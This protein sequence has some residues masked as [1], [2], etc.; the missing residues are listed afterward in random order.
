M[1][2]V[3]LLIL[4]FIGF[5]TYRAYRNG[6]IREL[7][8][9]CGVVLAVPLAGIFYDDMFPKV[10]PIVDNPELASLISFIAILAGVIIGAQVLAYFLRSAVTMLNL[11]VLDEIAGGLFGFLKGIL[12]VQ[13]LLIA[14]WVFPSPDLRKSIEASP[15]A[16]RLIDA[17]PFALAILP[18]Q[19]DDIIARFP[20]EFGP[21]PEADEA[22]ATPTPAPR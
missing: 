15:V 5:I 9:L 11:G 10:E 1:N 17:S 8:S 22:E 7:V 2:W 14:S 18:K 13:V 20:D 12:V 19:F 21:E 16:T 3:T 6:F 4:V